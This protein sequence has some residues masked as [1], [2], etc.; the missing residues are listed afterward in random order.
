MF[1]YIPVFILLAFLLLA[2]TVFEF[3]AFWS[4]PDPVFN[5]NRPFYSVSGIG[6]VFLSLLALLQF[7][8]GLA[9]LR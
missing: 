8:W 4:I 6:F 7:V 2:L 3:L 5:P 1:Y 9:F